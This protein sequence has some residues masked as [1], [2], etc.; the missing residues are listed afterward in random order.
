MAVVGHVGILVVGDW[1]GIRGAFLVEQKQKNLIRR[2]DRQ[3][4]TAW[5]VVDPG[6]NMNRERLS[7]K[8]PAQADVQIMKQVSALDI[9][10]KVFLRLAC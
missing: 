7:P 5:V 6:H 10:D 4:H 8:I 9:R 1:A 3:P 2:S